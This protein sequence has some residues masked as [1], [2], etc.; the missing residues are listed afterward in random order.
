MPLS[1]SQCEQLCCILDCNLCVYVKVCAP[2]PSVGVHLQY[3]TTL[4]LFH[5]SVSRPT[6]C[7]VHVASV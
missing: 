2:M 5:P 1:Y 4:D 3:C 6:H 7:V